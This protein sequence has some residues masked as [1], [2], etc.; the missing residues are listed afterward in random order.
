MQSGL[1]PPNTQDIV[2]AVPLQAMAKS[3]SLTVSAPVYAVGQAASFTM[4]VASKSFRADLTMSKNASLDSD[5]ELGRAIG[6]I[7]GK[8]EHIATKTWVMWTFIAWAAIVIA[9]F[10]GCLWVFGGVFFPPMLREAVTAAVQ[11]A[12]HK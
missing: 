1:P 2:L 9:S 5:S 8:L 11:Q 4:N 10:V 3:A 7:E 12:L 6:R